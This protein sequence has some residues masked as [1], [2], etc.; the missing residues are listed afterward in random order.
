LQKKGISSMCQRVGIVCSILL[1]AGEYMY[2]SCSFRFFI[3]PH[4]VL[5]TKTHEL[6]VNVLPPLFFLLLQGQVRLVHVDLSPHLFKIPM[7]HR[8]WRFCASTCSYPLQTEHI[9][10]SRVFRC[11]SE[12][13]PL[14]TCLLKWAGISPTRW[15]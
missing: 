10:S 4:L 1:A 9:T 15:E 2:S 13:D 8:T 7:H 3:I 14:S 12:T 11:S 5:S 6:Q